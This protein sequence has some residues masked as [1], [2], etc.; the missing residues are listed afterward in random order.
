MGEGRQKRLSD[1]HGLQM[2]L[3]CSLSQVITGE[4]AL[5]KWECAPSKWKTWDTRNEGPPT[6]DSEDTLHE[7]TLCREGKVY[8]VAHHTIKLKTSQSHETTILGGQRDGRVST[9]DEGG[10]Q[11]WILTSHR[12][13]SID[14]TK[15]ET[16]RRS[17]ENSPFRE[18][19]VKTKITH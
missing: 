11:S 9:F 14:D 10:C 18:M 3:P 8:Y 4:C 5:P 1:I 16:Y 7:R 6:G 17:K 12:E 2:C 15:V 19:A 13:K